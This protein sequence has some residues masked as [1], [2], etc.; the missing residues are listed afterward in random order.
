MATS[1]VAQALPLGG[2]VVGE[3]GVARPRWAAS[4][5]LMRAYYDEE[6]GR[7]VRDERGMFEQLSLEVFQAGLSWSTVLRKRPA[8]RAAFAQFDPDAVAAFGAEDVERLMASPG[9]VR[10]RKK[11]EATIVNA[12]A[13]AALRSAGGLAAVVW[14]F[15]PSAQATSFQAMDPQAGPA[16][17]AALLAKALRAAGFAFV[18]PTTMH[19]LM[20]AVGVIEARPAG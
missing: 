9:I 13:T 15:A 10:N 18:G 2:M 4:D 14:S 3:D 5:P 6:W 16:P 11:I 17:E 1:P 7:P 19:A 12:R 8:F 20:Q